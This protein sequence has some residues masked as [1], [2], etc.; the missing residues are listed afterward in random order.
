MANIIPNTTQV[1]DRD[2]ERS[3]LMKILRRLNLSAA[4]SP[5]VPASN[6]TVTNTPLAID[7]DGTQPVNVVGQPHVL[8][9][10]MPL[11]QPVSGAV[12][13]INFPANQTVNGTVAV[14]NFPATQSVT[15]TVGVA[16]LDFTVCGH[17]NSMAVPFEFEVAHEGL[18][19]ET[20]ANKAAFIYRMHGRRAGFNSTS[21]Q[22]DVGEYLGTSLD[23][24]TE[25]TGVEALQLVSSS[26]NDT[27]LGSGLRRVRISYL[28]T[29]YVLAFVEYDLNGVTPITVAERMLFVY[30]MEAVTGGVLE[31][32]A[33]N[34]DLRVTGTGVVH[35]RINT[36]SN[37]SRSARFMVPDNYKAYLMG[38]SAY[39]V[40]TTMDARLR[41]TTVSFCNGLNFRYL[42]KSN[43]LLSSGQNA[44][45]DLVYRQLPAR[46]KCKIAVIPGAAPVANRIDTEAILLLVQ[47]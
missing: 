36:N 5:G 16:G 10:N 41:A 30:C 3:L 11:T 32:A 21:V 24:F 4:V 43:M 2:N 19:R 34:V 46:A 8:V 35:E 39:S 42:V 22:Q 17:L 47:D 38:W 29:S 13:V 9:D 25:L 14:S 26:A 12:A 45:Q 40:G 44:T 27:V 31:G 6:V 28:N 37:R 18:Y 23:L 15:G 7:F 33:G 20:G 1:A